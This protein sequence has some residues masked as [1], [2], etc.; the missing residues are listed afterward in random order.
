MATKSIKFLVVVLVILGSQSY[1]QSITYNLILF[2]S[3]TS[4]YSNA[5]LYSLEKGRLSYSISDTIG[6]IKL[7]SIGHYTLKSDLRSINRRISI[8]RGANFDTLSTWRIQKYLA[9]G[10]HPEFIGYYCCDEKCDGF[11]Q[12]FYQNGNVRVEGRFKKGLVR[13]EIK[14]YNPDGSISLI[15]IYDNKGNLKGSRVPSN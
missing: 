1:S 13:G 7:D 4:E 5:L 2:D 12:D 15:R 14:F 9:P 10:L 11:Q 3:C 8:D 6:T